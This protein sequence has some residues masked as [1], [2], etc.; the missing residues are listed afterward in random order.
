MKVRAKVPVFVNGRLHAVGD[1][2]ETERFHE[3][4][5]ERVHKGGRP[6]KSEEA[7]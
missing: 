2:F 4:T 7:K 1:E 3:P 6:R 5:M